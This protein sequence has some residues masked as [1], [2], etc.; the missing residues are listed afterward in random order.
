[1]HKPNNNNQHRNAFSLHWIGCWIFN[2]NFSIRSP[3]SE[4]SGSWRIM[5]ARI[6]LQSPGEINLA[7][8]LSRFA[9]HIHVSF[10][11]SIISKGAQCGCWLKRGFVVESSSAASKG[12][13]RHGR[14]KSFCKLFNDS[15]QL[16][17]IKRSFIVMFTQNLKI[18]IS[19]P[20]SLFYPHWKEMAT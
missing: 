14:R 18:D 9:Y 16:W 19:P 2:D 5:I 15:H 3:K 20:F 17:I 1:M 11:C 7:R 13:W 4:Q 10:Q 6:L 8:F 12:G